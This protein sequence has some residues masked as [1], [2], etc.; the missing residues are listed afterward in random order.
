MFHN[1]FNVYKTAI[2]YCLS[3]QVLTVKKQ[4]Q[5]NN[6]QTGIHG[7][8]IVINSINVNEK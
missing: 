3:F 5:T 4:Q 7:N 1:W 6:K 8:G 2:Y